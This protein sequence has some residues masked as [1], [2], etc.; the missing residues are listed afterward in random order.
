MQDLFHVITIITLIFQSN[1]F[2]LDRLPV[3]ILHTSNH[4]HKNDF[5]SR[6]N[7]V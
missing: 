1:Q 6:E 5:K 7:F 2:K 3:T 4:E